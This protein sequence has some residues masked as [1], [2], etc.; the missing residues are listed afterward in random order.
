MGGVPQFLGE[1]ETRRPDVF[2]LFGG[3]DS[4]SDLI[5]V[6]GSS[7]FVPDLFVRLGERPPKSGRKLI[8][9]FSPVLAQ[10]GAADPCLGLARNAMGLAFVV[11]V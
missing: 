1:P 4:V 10:R 6:S 2:W 11:L 7:I 8:K 9:H 3:H 5:V